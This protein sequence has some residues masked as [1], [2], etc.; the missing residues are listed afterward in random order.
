[1]IPAEQQLQGE[2]GTRVNQLLVAN[3]AKVS[4]GRTSSSSIIIG[5]SG[6]TSRGRILESRGWGVITHT[7]DTRNVDNLL[8]M[9]EDQE[10][11][12]VKGARGAQE[13]GQHIRISTGDKQ[14]NNDPVR[15]GVRVHR[16]PDAEQG[17]S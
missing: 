15:G 11:P 1:M 10:V 6:I 4:I 14:Q 17:V 12:Q 7:K 2:L 5:N 3:R 16:A 8:V 9:R 13:V